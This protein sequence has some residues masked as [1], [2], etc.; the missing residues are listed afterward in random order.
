MTIEAL[1][2]RWNYTP[3]QALRAPVWVLQTTALLN[4]A[5][6]D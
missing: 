1:C 2:Q 4:M 6:R 5:R 3:E